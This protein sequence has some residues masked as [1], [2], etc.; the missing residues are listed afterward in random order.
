MRINLEPQPF[1]VG[2]VVAP[3]AHGG[4]PSRLRLA[5]WNTLLAGCLFFLLTVCSRETIAADQSVQ[6]DPAAHALYTQMV[7]AMRKATTLS[8]ISD[9]RWE[10]E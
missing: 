1:P 6:D 10:P 7:E 5:A 9:Y 3:A 2:K 4:L 8:W